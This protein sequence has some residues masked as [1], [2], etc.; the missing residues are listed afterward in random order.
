MLKL[1]I[2]LKIAYLNVII[3]QHYIHDRIILSLRGVILQRVKAGITMIDFY[4]KLTFSNPQLL[5]FRAAI[6]SLDFV[7]HLSNYAQHL[8]AGKRL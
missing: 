1:F 6:Q 8:Q 3:Q 7:N 5:E 2:Q 4:L